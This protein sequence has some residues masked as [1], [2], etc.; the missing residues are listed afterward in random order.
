MCTSSGLWC[1]SYD[2]RTVCSPESSAAL[3]GARPA[4]VETRVS[5][6]TVVRVGPLVGGWTSRD[7]YLK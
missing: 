4:P 5:P 6:A 3:T 1:L 7:P 2:R